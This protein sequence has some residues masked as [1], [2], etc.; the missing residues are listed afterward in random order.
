MIANGDFIGFPS[1]L[2][3]QEHLFAFV[4][5]LSSIRHFILLNLYL[6]KNSC[7]SCCNLVDSWIKGRALPYPFEKLDTGTVQR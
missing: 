2:F 7:L 3:L 4:S 1:Y 6:G 5:W